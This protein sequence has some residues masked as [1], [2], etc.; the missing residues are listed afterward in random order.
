[1]CLRRQC[2]HRCFVFLA[3]DRFAD[4]PLAFGVDP[5]R[6]RILGVQAMSCAARIGQAVDER[7][8]VIHA[9]QGSAGNFAECDAAA[10]REPG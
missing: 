2:K 5:D 9:R 1:M 6:G 3:V 7:D 8:L 10:G 4:E